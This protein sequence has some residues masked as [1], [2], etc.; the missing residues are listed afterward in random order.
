MRRCRRLLNTAPTKFGEDRYGAPVQCK[1]LQSTEGTAQV[2]A[3]PACVPRAVQLLKPPAS[4]HHFSIPSDPPFQGNFDERTQRIEPFLV[5]VSLAAWYRVRCN[6][7]TR[8]GGWWD[9]VQTLAL[10][11]QW[12][13]LS[14]SP[15]CRVHDAYT[16]LCA[17]R[18]R[19]ATCAAAVIGGITV[20]V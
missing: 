6:D 4:Q 12:H 7:S 19:P 18:S 11:V 5:R 2:H 10:T 13:S 3:S 20:G 17:R 14:L 15:V 9:R 1:C 8:P 16:I